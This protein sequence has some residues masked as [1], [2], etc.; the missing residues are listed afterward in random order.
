MVNHAQVAQG[1]RWQVTG[2]IL[3]VQAAVP[4]RLRPAFRP[5]GQDAGQEATGQNA[6]QARLAVSRAGLALGGAVLAGL[7]V[8]GSLSKRDRP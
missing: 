4:A 8:S 2:L 6:R 1:Q 5:S 7:A 3:L